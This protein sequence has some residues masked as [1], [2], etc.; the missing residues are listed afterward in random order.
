MRDWL[1]YRLSDLLLFSPRT[2]YRMFELYHEEIWPAQLVALAFAVA[3]L[4]ALWRGE[5]WGGA[6]IA[7]LLATSWL[8]VAIAF[9][10]QRYA[11]INWAARYFSVLFLMQAALLVWFGLVRRQLTFRRLGNGARW[12]APTLVFVAFVL[13]PLAGRATDREWGQVELAGLTPD[14]TAVATVGLLLLAAPRAPR[15]LML[16]PLGWCA[17][18]GATL[19]AMESPEAWVSL[20]AAVVGLLAML[21]RQ[22]HALPASGERPVS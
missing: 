2:Y 22:A 1:T 13:P 7:A 8:W 21:L 3:I 12:S 5:T 6:A 11:T 18:A 16:V 15:A 17:V 14:A 19:W 9:H 10:V 4:V 20:G